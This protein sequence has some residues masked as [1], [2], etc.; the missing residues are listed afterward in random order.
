L[1]KGI[2]VNA[3]GSGSLMT[4]ML[5]EVASDAGIVNRILS[6]THSAIVGYHGRSKT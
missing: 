1:S 2:H 6:R 5:E 3:I 4:E